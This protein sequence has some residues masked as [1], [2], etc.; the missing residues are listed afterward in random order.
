MNTTLDKPIDECTLEELQALG[1]QGIDKSL[2][3]SLGEYG[4]AC[5]YNPEDQDYHCIIGYQ[6]ADGDMHYISFY[7]GHFDDEDINEMARE[8]G[9]AEFFDFIGDIPFHWRK[10]PFHSRAHDLKTWLGPETVF[11]TASH[12]FQLI[13][14]ST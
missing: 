13:G 5:R 10:R 11:G 6:R 7:C 3:I 4:L 1:Y 14:L 2:E 12:T 8:L 9:G